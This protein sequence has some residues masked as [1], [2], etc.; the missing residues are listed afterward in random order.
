MVWR[1]SGAVFRPYATG[2][3]IWRLLVRL[4]L[5]ARKRR[6]KAQNRILAVQTSLGGE[7]EP[8]GR[9][10]NEHQDGGEEAQACRAHTHASLRH[11]LLAAGPACC[12]RDARDSR[13]DAPRSAQKRSGADEA[14][15]RAPGVSVPRAPRPRQ[16]LPWVHYQGLMAVERLPCTTARYSRPGTWSP[17]CATLNSLDSLRARFV[18]SSIRGTAL[19]FAREARSRGI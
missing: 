18:D 8:A 7:P 4:G 11:L 1:A 10:A 9:L 2:L 17:L 6:K 14:P 19:C 3:L 12:H 13:G 5:R 16:C 15:G